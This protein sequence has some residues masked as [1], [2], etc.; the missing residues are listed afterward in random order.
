MKIC[1][2]THT[3]PRFLG[4]P[5]APFIHTLAESLVREGNKVVVLS[6]YNP[7]ID[8]NFK[9]NYKMVTYKYI[10]PK[11][12]HIL[13]Y[14]QTLKGDRS[15]GVLGYIFSP[16]LYFFGFFALLKL[17]LIEKV[18]II[19][20]HWIIPNGFIAALVSKI[21]KVP[22]TVTIPGSDIYLGGKNFFFR[23]MVSYASKNAA[24]VI[25]DS[26]YYLT[27]LNRL[28]LY[29]V[30]TQIIR[31]GV[32]INKFKPITKSSRNTPTILA[33]GRMVP[34]KGFRY[35]IEAM[36]RIIE[37]VP[38]VKLL[39]VGDGEERKFLE[40]EA[41]SIGVYKKI[42]FVGTVSYLDLPR[43]YQMADVL[44]MPSIK[45]EKG[46]IDASPV[47]MMEAMSAGIPVVA[48]NFAGDDGL[49]IDG[50]TGYL[51]KNT[52]P[53]LI[54]SAV[55][56]VLTKGYKEITRRKV[57]KVAI[58]NFSSKIIAKK[59]TDCFFNSILRK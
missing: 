23:W 10:F 57:R 27:E 6:G 55:V 31:Y 33:V 7:E 2:F 32:D 49:I 36:P 5:S 46:N 21:T 42:D 4:D 56:K 17:V 53:N 44:V 8:V 19:S 39:M 47:S 54:S 50:E 28:G 40:G 16:F 58:S 29:P 35:L 26:C 37:R 59:Y 11:N 22:Y 14:S 30:K 52:K 24:V 13:G 1:L 34:K 48:T 51:I 38:K 20:S 45:D 3:I 9:R 18:D 43:Y 25:S 15:L 12:F 41:K